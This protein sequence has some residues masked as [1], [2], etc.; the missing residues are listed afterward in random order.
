MHLSIFL[1][2]HLSFHPTIYLSTYEPH[3]PRDFFE[4]TSN[5]FA[6]VNELSETD[7]VNGENDTELEAVRNKKLNPRG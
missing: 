4:M 7:V 1:L 6:I 5:I 3:P 2:F